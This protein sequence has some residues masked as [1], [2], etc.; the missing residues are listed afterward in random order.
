MPLG[1]LVPQV[2]GTGPSSPYA[3]QAVTVEGVVTAAY[4]TGGIN[5]FYL[6]TAGTGADLTTDDQDAHTASDAVLVYGSAATAKVGVG[7]H[8]R[9]TGKVSEFQGTTEITPT[10]ADVTVLPTP[11]TVTPAKVTVPRTEA[12]REAF[13]G[14]LLAPQGPFTVADNYGLNSYGEVGLASGTTPLVAPTEVADAQ[15]TATIARLTAENDARA[16]TLDDGATVNFLGAGK[17]APLPY[18]TQDHQVRVGAPVTFA[19]PVVLEDR[20]DV[21]RLQPTSQLT[22]EGTLPVTFGHTR[23]A[24][25]EPVGGNVKIASFNVLNYFPTTGDDV[26]AAGGSCSFY[27]DRAGDPVTVN[28]C[29]TATGGDGPRG[30]AEDEDLARQQAKIVAAID[31]LGA[32]V[33]S[34]EEIENSAKF[35]KDRDA[36]VGRLVAALNAADPGSPRGDWRFVPS[37]ASANSPE[38]QADEDVIR[39]AFIYRSGVVGP[40]GESVIDDVPTFDTARDPLAQAFQPVGAGTFSRFT[41][42]VNHLKSKGS[43]VDDGT[44]QGNSNPTRVA[45]AKEVVRFADAM[46]SELGTDRQF[47]TGDFNAYTQ[48]DPL[49][50]LYAAGWTDIGSH[51]H[52]EEHTY[53]F[54]GTV[55]SLDHVL[56]NAAA[57]RSVTGAHVWNLSSVESVALE[58]SRVNYNATDLYEPGPYRSS[59]HDPLLVG[60]SLPTGPVATTT[61]AT[62]DPDPVEF[63]RDHPVVTVRV[64]TDPADLGT[65]DEGTVEVREGGVVVGRGTV[66]DGVARVDLPTT[67]K[68]GRHEVTVTYLGTDDAAGSTGTAAYD[69]V[70]T[71]PVGPR[72]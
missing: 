25:P 66:T 52:P 21:W 30:A 58:Y 46:R 51:L 28:T 64:A 70:K 43:G 27:K 33:V 31:G 68:K 49:Q 50:E 13:E 3:G 6:Q 60:V 62:V 55:G 39:T 37:P 8:V 32:D 54:G 4:P 19:A 34:L 35:G 1:F 2:Q 44:G 67:N 42:V 40:V 5:S 38:A 22:G 69:V 10:A 41:V 18:L 12:G 45:Q 61:T 9:V 15:D 59:D 65:V 56:G 7:D 71:G 57:M 36:A 24:A 20:Y 53:L 26:V 23:T 29:R 48:E 14:M 16:V 17:D 47:L 63:K 72:P 11:A